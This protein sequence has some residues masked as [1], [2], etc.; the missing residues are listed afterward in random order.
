MSII[1]QSFGTVTGGEQADIFTLTNANGMRVEITNY[2]C[3]IVRLF[4]PDKNGQFNDIVLGFDN[5]ESYLKTNPFF[6]SIVGRCA[7]RIDGGKFSLDGT[8][9]QLDKNRNGHHLHGGVKGFDKYLWDVEIENDAKGEHLKLHHISEDGDEGYPGTV[10][11]VVMYSLN[12]ENELA[13]Q[14]IAS[15][16]KATV[17]NLTNHCYFNLSGHS[18]GDI[19]NHEV[20]INSDKYTAVNSELITSGEIKSVQNT[21]F[22]FLK[23]TQIGLRISDKELSNCGGYDVNYVLEGKSGVLRKAAE[24]Y[25]PVSG[26]LMEVYT[27][28]PGVQFYTGNFIN[29]PIAGKEGYAYN[30]YSGLCF[31]TQFYPDAINHPRFPS[32]ILRPGQK[33]NH[34]TIYKFSVDEKR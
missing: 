21:P 14:Y 16:D 33:Y 19:L 26:R 12:N 18:S 1:R 27:T 2:G 17:V 10:D 13:I 8:E 31:E 22:D 24:V 4:V 11:V 7:N 32:P 3:K 6:G 20:K 29:G 34:K 5:I 23:M 15:T 25:E 30:K 9:Y 28:M